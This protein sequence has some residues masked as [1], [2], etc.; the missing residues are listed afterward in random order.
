MMGLRGISGSLEDQSTAEPEF[1]DFVPSIKD[2]VSQTD[3]ENINDNLY[4]KKVL[5]NEGMACCQSVTYVK[6]ELIGDPL[7]IK[8]LEDTEWEL[9][10]GSAV[11]NSQIGGDDIVLAHVRPKRSPDH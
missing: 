9:D 6:D 7:E 8:L 11:A 1:T 3:I 4:A 2:L 10:E 5:L